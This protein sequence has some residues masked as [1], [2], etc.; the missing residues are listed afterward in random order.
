MA[1]VTIQFS[2]GSSLWLLNQG[3]Q[4]KAPWRW[5]VLTRSVPGVTSAV[6]S[7]ASPQMLA[8]RK[9]CKHPI[10]SYQIYLPLTPART[11]LLTPRTWTNVP[12]GHSAF[13]EIS[14]SR[15]TG[16]RRGSFSTTKLRLRLTE[17]F[18]PRS[19]NSWRS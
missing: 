4:P 17:S 8:P 16:L 19:Q 15:P 9:F 11:H 12:T 5:K 3:P 7:A 2:G 1:V 18:C 13:R 14:F 6:V 10:S